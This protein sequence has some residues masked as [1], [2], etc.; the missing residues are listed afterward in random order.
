[1]AAEPRAVSTGPSRGLMYVLITGQ[2]LFNVLIRQSLPTLLLFMGLEFGWSDSTKSMLLGAFFPGYLTTQLPAGWAA[3]RYGPKV[4]F[5][6]N[7]LGH[8][9]CLALPAAA[10]AANPL[11]LAGCLT[12]I[13]VAQGPMIPVQGALKANWLTKGPVRAHCSLVS[14]LACPV[15]AG[16]RGRRSTERQLD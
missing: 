6:L 15:C 5:T 8:T 9:L 2:Q 4:I 16:S 13:G 14:T 10:S 12:A 1:M 11:W 7:L 3:Q